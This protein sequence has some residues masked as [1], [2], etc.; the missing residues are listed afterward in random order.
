MC[1]SVCDSNSREALTV[2]NVISDMCVRLRTAEGQRKKA[3]RHR[4]SQRH[5]GVGRAGR[6]RNNGKARG[7][8]GTSE[9]ATK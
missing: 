3:K 2:V 8:V 4:Q 6:K 1:A 5:R 9:Q 7:R